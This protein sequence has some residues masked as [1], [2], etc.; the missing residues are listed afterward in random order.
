MEKNKTGKYLKYALGEIILVVTGILIA[1]QINIWND[2]KKQQKIEIEILTEIQNNLTTDLEDHQQNMSFIE[3][4]LNGSKKLLDNLS[5]AQFN[6][7]IGPLISYIA[8][9]APHAN[10]VI[11]GYNRMLASDA[12]IISNDSIRSQIS[13][14]YENHYT[15]LSNIFKELFLTQTATMNNLILEN[16]IIK[17]SNSSFPIYEPN[18]F[19]ELKNNTIFLTTLETHM[20]YWE[21]VQKRYMEYMEEIKKVITNIDREISTKG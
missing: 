21:I 7:S 4:R 18:N 16:F 20:K 6:D 5:S 12:E 17:E 13:I 15:W 1:L 10:P 2:E 9:A 14:I 8:F 3:S 11:S 19:M